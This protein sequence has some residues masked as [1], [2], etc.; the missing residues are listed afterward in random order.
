MVDHLN[1]VFCANVYNEATEI[2]AEGFPRHQRD[3]FMEQGACG[4]GNY[5]LGDYFSVLSDQSATYSQPY[6]H[7]NCF[8]EINFRRRLHVAWPYE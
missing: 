3:L 8:G 2:A 5:P 1:Q 6:V 4:R 7:A